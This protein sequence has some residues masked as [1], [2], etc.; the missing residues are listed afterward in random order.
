M[1]KWT[2]LLI[3]LV[4]TVLCA[5]AF[6]EEEVIESLVNPE[7]VQLFSS[8]WVDG[9][10][11]VKIYAEEN[12]WMVRITSADG[13][14]EWDYNCLYNEEQKALVS[15]DD[16]VNIKT[17]IK[18]DDE[19]SEIGRREIY[20]D[21]KAVFTVNENGKLIWQD[22]KENAGEGLAFERIGWYQG[23]WISGDSIE[24]R[25]ELNCFWDVEQSAE[26]EIHSGYK[27]EITKYDGDACTIWNYTCDYNP[28]NNTL[29]SLL[30]S[31]EHSEKEGDPIVTVYD[32]GEAAFSMDEEGCVRWND[33][34]ENAGEGLQ[35]SPT[36]G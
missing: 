6:A 11:S 34:K 33:L 3:A 5:A 7:A 4:M 10:A 26:G 13:A 14:T 15:W 18:I 8:E 20:T 21:G 32:D 31:K 36:N 16:D 1:K 22:E 17:E 24:S 29:K 28:E 9:F 35:F 30:G 23:V 25:C 2:A 19:G 12:H 27:V